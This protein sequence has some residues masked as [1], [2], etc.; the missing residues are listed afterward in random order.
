MTRKFNK[1]E[2]RFFSEK[3]AAFYLG[4]SVSMLRNIRG[5]AEIEYRVYGA[6]KKI[7]YD[8]E[9]LDEAADRLF[10]RKKITI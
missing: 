9:N 7:I 4:I 8:I 10:T 3:E 1:Q 6:G 5:M 2:K